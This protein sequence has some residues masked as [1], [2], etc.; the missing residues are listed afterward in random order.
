MSYDTYI[1]ANYVNPA[2]VELLQVDAA[3]AGGLQRLKQIR[4]TIV[5]G[6]SYTDKFCLIRP[7]WWSSTVRS[8]RA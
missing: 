5:V 8:L 3:I 1:R 6:L 4:V 7:S 2:K